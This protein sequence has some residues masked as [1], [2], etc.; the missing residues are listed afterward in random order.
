MPKYFMVVI[1]FM[2]LFGCSSVPVRYAESFETIPVL[3]KNEAR[4]FFYRLDDSPLYWLRGASVDI[5]GENLGSSSVGSAFYYDVSPGE[6]IIETDMSDLPGSCQVTLQARAGYIYH[7][8]V[9]AR[10]ESFNTMMKNLYDPLSG[11]ARL[12]LDSLMQECSGAFAIVPVPEAKA[13]NEMSGLK[14]SN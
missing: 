4:I 10:W 11:M 6:H 3:D 9:T 7:F 1:V 8:K 2:A 13:L 12:Y 5:D 14:I